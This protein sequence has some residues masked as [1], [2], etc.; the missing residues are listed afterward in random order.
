[1]RVDRR[2]GGGGAPGARVGRR[3]LA[4]VR[5]PPRQAWPR[6]GFCTFNGLALAARAALAAGVRGVLVID[7]DAHCGGGTANLLADEPRVAQL[8]V[9]VSGFD[10][11]QEPAGWTLDLVRRG[12]RVP[13]DRCGGAST[14]STRPRFGLVLYNAGMDPFEGCDVGGLEGITRD[15]LAEREDAVFAWCRSAGLPVAFVL[16][17]GYT[18]HRLARTSSWTSTA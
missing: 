7:L 18:G 1:M 16:A 12:R 2:R 13:P 11:Y 3:R 5:A 6:D 17:G 10:I 15:V 8:D 4:L 9:A 14:P